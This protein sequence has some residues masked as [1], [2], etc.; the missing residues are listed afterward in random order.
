MVKIL[1][2]RKLKFEHKITMSYEKREEKIQMNTQARGTLIRN[3]GAFTQ[4]RDEKFRMN[5]QA[6]GRLMRNEGA[7]TQ[8]PNDVLTGEEAFLERV[9]KPRQLQENNNS[10]QEGKPKYDSNLNKLLIIL[11]SKGKMPAMQ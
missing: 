5:T 2:E 1:I 11:G 6:R 9:R 10:Y 4:H 8:P 3:E 7:F